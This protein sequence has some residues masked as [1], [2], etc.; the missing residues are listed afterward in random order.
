MQ[1]KVQDGESGL[2]F[3]VGNSR[4]LVKKLE[5]AITPSVRATLRNGAQAARAG[6]LTARDYVR[7]YEELASVQPH[8]AAAPRRREKQ[9]ASVEVSV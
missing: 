8:K 2:H 1:E 6:V 3:E 9:P 7:L 4:D 5:L